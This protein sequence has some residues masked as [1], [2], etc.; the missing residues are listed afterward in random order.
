MAKHYFPARWPSTIS[1]SVL[2]ALRLGELF[3]LIFHYF[4]NICGLLTNTTRRLACCSINN[5]RTPL[6]TF[7]FSKAAIAKRLDWRARLNGAVGYVAT[8]SCRTDSLR[9][10]ERSYRINHRSVRACGISELHTSCSCRGPHPRHRPKSTAWDFDPPP[11]NSLAMNLSVEKHLA[12]IFVDRFVP[13]HSCGTIGCSGVKMA[14]NLTRVRII[15]DGYKDLRTRKQIT[16]KSQFI[17][18]RWIG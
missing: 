10:R 7:W 8:Y 17:F 14:S 4:D 11:P 1:D 6:K 9:T 16:F 2:G 5:P 18:R 12:A 15:F 3:C 13:R